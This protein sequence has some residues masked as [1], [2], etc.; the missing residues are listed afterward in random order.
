MR[1]RVKVEGERERMRREERREGHEKA[2]R[3]I[4]KQG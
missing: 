3:R 2:Q 1:M 4:K